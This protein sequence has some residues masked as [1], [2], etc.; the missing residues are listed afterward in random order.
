MSSLRQLGQMKHSPN[1]I[2]Q[3]LAGRFCCYSRPRVHLQSLGELWRCICRD[4]IG[5]SNVVGCLLGIV[6]HLSGSFTSV[7]MKE[8]RQVEEH[9]L[10]V[11][12]SDRM[13][14]MS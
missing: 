9:S 1:A 10:D 14:D 8:R 5:E 13:I 2:M 12:C 6:F 3:R 4:R 11:P 7:Q